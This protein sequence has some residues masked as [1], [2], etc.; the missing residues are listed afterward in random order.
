M[1]LIDCF[2]GCLIAPNIFFPPLCFCEG[3]D[4]ISDMTLQKIL[5]QKDLLSAV[6]GVIDAIGVSLA[7]HGNDGSCLLGRD[8]GGPMEKYPVEIS[9][10]V[11]GWVAGTEEVRPVAALLSHLAGRE[12]ERRLLATETLDRYKEIS[13]IYNFV[14][15]IALCL[16]LNEVTKLVIEETR[17]NIRSTNASVMLLNQRTR[18]LEIISASGKE[19]SPKM[20]LKP[21][22]GIGIAG[23][24]FFT[25]KAEIVNNVASDPRYIKGANRISSLMCAPLK[26]RDKVIGVINVSSEHAAAYTA[27][28]LK[29]LH[30]LTSQAALVIENAVFH[31]NQ[32]KEERIKSNLER[33]VAPQIVKAIMESKKNIVFSPTKRNITVLFSDIRNFT[34]TCEQQPPEKIVEYLNEY[35]THMVDV[36]FTY[37][38]TLNKFVG[39]MIVAFFGAPAVTEKNEQRAIEAAI[40]MQ[41]RITTIP[42]QWIQNNFH[43]GIGIN[44]GEVV[45]GNIGSPHH[46]DYTAIGDEVNTGSRLQS[47]A[48]GGQILVSRSVYEAT[49]DL[50]PFKEI[51][52]VQVKGKN[53]SVEVFEVQY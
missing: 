16:N 50:F 12:R 35:F 41:K 31:E 25:G 51:G 47:M 32:L 28:N 53:R 44:S 10:D 27:A 14:D 8:S 42:A 24:V 34:T 26:T 20:A 13:L 43:T 33:Y 11:I 30:M 52:S 40:D 39:D 1:L 18:N 3:I 38:G 21:G 9:G 17:K 46:M 4:I 49:R 6:N 37:G 22:V 5:S 2:S 15:K 45:V 29:L 19:Y 23:T 36:I 7:V 48:K